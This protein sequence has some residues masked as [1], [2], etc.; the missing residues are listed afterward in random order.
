MSE[1]RPTRIERLPDG[2]IKIQWSDGHEGVYPPRYLRLHCPCAG[3]V[4][5]WSGERILKPEQVPEDIRP[6]WIQQV[7]WYAIQIR[8]SDGH[9][10]GIYPFDLLRSLCPCSSCQG[11]SSS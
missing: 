4:D 6:E 5:E 10:T 3:C 7:G 11:A 9:E 1:V 8:W 2:Q